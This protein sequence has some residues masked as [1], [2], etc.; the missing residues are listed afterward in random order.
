MIIILL[1]PNNMSIHNKSSLCSC[2]PWAKIFI[3]RLGYQVC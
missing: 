2:I 1:H 3:P